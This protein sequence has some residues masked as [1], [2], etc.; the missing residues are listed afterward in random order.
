MKKFSPAVTSANGP[1][2]KRPLSPQARR[3]KRGAAL[4]YALVIMLICFTL[5]M[6]LLSVCVLAFRQAQL[7]D[8]LFQTQADSDL[9]GQRFSAWLT[10]E[11]LSAVTVSGAEPGSE[12]EA[13][14]RN[15]LNDFIQSTDDDDEASL[16]EFISGPDNN[17][18]ISTVTYTCGRLTVVY[19][20]TFTESEGG[21]SW[22]G[23]AELKAWTLGAG[24]SSGPAPESDPAEGG[25]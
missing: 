19:E 8:T 20:C 10:Q 6:A 17:T 11:G 24:N 2:G 9:Q 12:I 5:C 1:K 15:K 16:S 23:S 21:G 25:A 18:F 4:G 14:F 3:A 13:A 7:Q 22:T